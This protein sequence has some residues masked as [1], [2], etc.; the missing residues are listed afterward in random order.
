MNTKSLQFA[1]LLLAFTIH[2]H[3]EENTNTNPCLNKDRLHKKIV[4]EIL[5]EKNDSNKL[6]QWF[7]WSGFLGK[8]I[9]KRQQFRDTVLKLSPDEQKAKIEQWLQKKSRI[10]NIQEFEQKVLLIAKTKEIDDKVIQEIVEL[11]NL[12]KLRIDNFKDELLYAACA[13]ILEEEHP[14]AAAK[15]NDKKFQHEIE[16]KLH[17]ARLRQ[18]EEEK[19]ENRKKELEELEQKAL[20]EFE[21]LNDYLYYD[22]WY[23]GR[24]VH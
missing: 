24:K 11:Y 13:G 14:E 10:Q 22:I 8:T 20:N 3:A 1:T 15:F 17:F 23:G 4:E 18:Y 2:I 6:L 7:I 5:A 21:S 12:F 19:F 9:K 16:T